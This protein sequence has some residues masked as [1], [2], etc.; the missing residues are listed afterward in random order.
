MTTITLEV[1]DDLAAQ[2]SPV[3]EHL[4]NLIAQALELLP[5]GQGEAILPPSTAFPVFDE[6][7][8]FL[9]SGPTPQQI[10]EYRVPARLQKRLE[11][12][13]ENNREK[14]L[15]MPE[16]VEVNAFRQVNHV[17]IRLKARARR[18]LQ[19]AA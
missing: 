7:I 5:V 12:L 13:L 3:R 10:I 18:A 14:G 8:D 4:P 15:A 17:L 1:S 16:A 11:K 6:M 2:L 9:A 19:S